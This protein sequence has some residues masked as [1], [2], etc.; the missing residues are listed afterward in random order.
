ME[1]KMTLIEKT[2]TLDIYSS[3]VPASQNSPPFQSTRAARS[4]HG[5]R[6]YLIFSGSNFSRM[7]SVSSSNIVSSHS[8]PH[9]VPSSSSFSSPP[10]AGCHFSS[11]TQ[12]TLRH[13]Q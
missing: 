2:R 6:R 4:L 7:K 3:W 9:S 8:S 1:H 12:Q 10:L 11:L 13:S 5:G